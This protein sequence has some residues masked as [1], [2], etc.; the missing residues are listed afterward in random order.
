MHLLGKFVSI[1]AQRCMLQNMLDIA[2]CTIYDNCI[3]HFRSTSHPAVELGGGN[4][5]KTTM[6]ERMRFDPA[7]AARDGAIDADDLL[8]DLQNLCGDSP[9]ITLNRALDGIIGLAIEN[10]IEECEARK[11]AFCDVIGPMLSRPLVPAIR[12]CVPLLAELQAA[13]SIIR[14]ALAVMTTE[15]KMTWGELN[16]RDHVAGEGITRANERALAIASASS[17]TDQAPRF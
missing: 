5:E 10:R 12:N 15:Q 11:A 3:D 4:L 14:N 8:V 2:C 16:E 9:A 13:H 17:E 7:G 1:V 6:N